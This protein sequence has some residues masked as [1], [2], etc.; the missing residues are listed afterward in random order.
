MLNI[1]QP[2]VQFIVAGH[3][4]SHPLG[5][6]SRLCSLTCK[7]L[8]FGQVRGHTTLELH[9]HSSPSCISYTEPSILPEFD[10]GN[11]SSCPAAQRLIAPTV[12]SLVSS[13]ID[14]R[15]LPPLLIVSGTDLS[16]SITRLP[17]VL[18]IAYLLP[19]IHSPAHF[20]IPSFAAGNPLS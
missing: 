10:R 5:H 2:M 12:A 8:R 3:L 6:R 16:W 20:F 19:R 17:H 4:E 15:T 13:R 11:Y 18:V 14:L 1:R 9:R 7:S